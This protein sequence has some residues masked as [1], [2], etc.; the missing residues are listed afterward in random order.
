MES[1]MKLPDDMFKQ[2]LLTYL[3]V[4]DIVRLDNACMNHQYRPQLLDKISGV[5]LRG[6]KVKCMK[7]SLYTWLGIRRIYWIKINLYFK[8]GNIFSS[9]IKNNYVDQFRY[10]QH[11]VMRGSIRDNM[12]IFI[13]SHCPCLLSIVVGDYN[14]PSLQITDHTLQSIAEHCTGRQS[15]SLIDCREITDTGLMT[16]SEHCNNLKSLKVCYCDHLT[17]ASIISISTHCTRLQTIYL[18][19]CNQITDASIISISTHCLGLH[20]L[21]LIDNRC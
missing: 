8:E 19:R 13:I 20:L 15:L 18:R 9:I 3:T 17:D 12:A 21:N 5:I 11:V 6:D 2:E 16:I 7:A 4:Y 10:T 1:M 14:Q